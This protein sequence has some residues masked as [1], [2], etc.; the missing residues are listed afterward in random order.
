M[1]VLPQLI[2]NRIYSLLYGTVFLLIAIDIYSD[3]RAELE[4]EHL[5]FEGSIMALCFIGMVLLT[6]SSRSMRQDR[7]RLRREL[8]EA[9][10]LSERF[11]KENQELVRGLGQAI[12]KQFRE[13]SLSPAESE[14][15]LLILKGL[16]HRE[17]AEIRETSERTVRQQSREVYRKAGLSGRAAL[18]A[19]FLEDLLQ[20]LSTPRDQSSS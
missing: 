20:P 3:M 5:L 14:V 8:S 2:Q 11:R 13:W 1:R 6:Q 16:S 10:A 12:E 19:Y 7:E 18:S 15:A 4:W 9:G 17:A